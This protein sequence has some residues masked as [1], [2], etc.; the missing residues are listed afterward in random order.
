M[1][2]ILTD[3]RTPYS[4]PELYPEYWEEE[5]D[6]A[7]KFLKEYGYPTLD[8]ILPNHDPSTPLTPTENYRV[9]YVTWKWEK[10]QG[11]W[12]EWGWSPR[13]IAAFERIVESFYF[14]STPFKEV[15]FPPDPRFYRL[16]GVPPEHLTP[17]VAAFLAL[18]YAEIPGWLR[19][20]IGGSSY[21]PRREVPSWVGSEEPLP[22]REL[23]YRPKPPP[24]PP[25]PEPE[26][27]EPPAGFKGCKLRG[28]YSADLTLGKDH[29][30]VSCVA[31]GYNSKLCVLKTPSLCG[32][33]VH[34]SVCQSYAQPTRVRAVALTQGD[35]QIYGNFGDIMFTR[36]SRFHPDTNTFDDP[37]STHIRCLTS[38]DTLEQDATGKVFFSS[39]KGYARSASP[40]GGYYEIHST[41][42]GVYYKHSGDSGE[43]KIFDISDALISCDCTPADE[44][45]VVAY[46]PST[47]EIHLR[48]KTIK[49]W[50][51]VSTYTPSRV[52][53]G[54]S[55]IDVATNSKGEVYLLVQIEQDKSALIRIYQ[56]KKL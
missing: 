4:H 50:S 39:E 47:N 48:V 35:V 21:D 38:D 22:R 51:D 9:M 12:E 1:L 15:D 49:G 52:W 13:R 46:D 5:W 19:Y 18:E 3:A 29:C 20:G 43:E 11:W 8:E 27:E 56:V 36:G 25:P 6:R 40:R 2:A 34:W 37:G 14:K 33:G 17:D 16:K 28:F 42:D 32:W 23:P 41:P 54:V 24:P 53:H 30:F 10:D 31:K 45:Y 44:L 26:E 55:A 7:N